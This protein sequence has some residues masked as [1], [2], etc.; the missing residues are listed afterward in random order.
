MFVNRIKELKILNDEYKKTKFSFSIIYGRRRV[1]KTFLI[2]EY[3]KQD[4]KT[5]AIHVNNS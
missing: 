5:V 2:R 4:I 1:G 3:F